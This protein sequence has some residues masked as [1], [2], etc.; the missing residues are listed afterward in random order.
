MCEDRDLFSVKKELETRKMDVRSFAVE[1]IPNVNVSPGEKD[2]ELIGKMMEK[3]ETYP[4]VIRVFINV[5][6]PES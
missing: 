2:M 6:A 4:D 1:F 3:L 5:Q